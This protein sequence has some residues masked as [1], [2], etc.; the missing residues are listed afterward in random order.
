MEKEPNVIFHIDS[1]KP[2]LSSEEKFWDETRFQILK[3]VSR[4]INDIGQTR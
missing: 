4:W 1:R 3:N 2:S